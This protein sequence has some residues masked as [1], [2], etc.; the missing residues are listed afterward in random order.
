MPSS[1]VK[2]GFVLNPFAGMGGSV[3]LKGTDGPAL[4]EAI[5]RGAKPKAMERAKLALGS[6]GDLRAIEFYTIGGPMGSDLLTEMDIEHE[7]VYAPPEHSEGKDTT[8]AVRLFCAIGCDLVI[9]CGGDGTARDVMEGMDGDVPCIG[10]PS[11]VKMHSGVFANSPR[12]AGTLIREFIRGSISLRRAEVMDI[13]EDMFREGLLSARPIGYLTVLDDS[14]LIQPSKGSLNASNDEEEKE[15]VGAYLATI[16]E[17]GT[18]YIL[19]PGTTVEA[20]AA[21]MGVEKTLLGVDVMRDGVIVVKDA[22]E[23]ELLSETGGRNFK[24]VVTPIG[25]QGFVFGRGNQQIS[26]AVIRSAGKGG[27]IIIATPGKLRRLKRLK[28]DTGDES[29]DDELAGHWKVII[30]FGRERMMRLE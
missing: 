30:G 6:A 17:V 5:A 13:D 11:G 7:V 24:I 25:A 21:E 26:P 22:G 3:G 4:D 16:V 14:A 20:F 2:F 19:G 8:E 15:E 23:K 28:A 18:T 10:V 12:D 9:F 1:S 29:L 27:I